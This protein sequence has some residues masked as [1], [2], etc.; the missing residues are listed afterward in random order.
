MDLGLEVAEATLLE[1]NFERNRSIGISE[2]NY[3][4]FRREEAKTT[5]VLLR[6]P[7]KK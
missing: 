4:L 2:A 7:T 1:Q 6:S 5:Y 3:L